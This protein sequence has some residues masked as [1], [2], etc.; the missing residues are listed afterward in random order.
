MTR[1]AEFE[2]DGVDSRSAPEQIAAQLHQALVSGS[3]QPGDRLPPEPELADGFG[4]SRSTVRE[5]LKLLRGQ[6]LLETQRGSK[7]GHFVATPHA[8]G[9]AAELGR[10]FGIW[11]DI[12]EISVAEVDEARHVVER[13]CVQLAAKRATREDLDEMGRILDAQADPSISLQEFLNLDVAFHQAISTAA[14]NYLLS[15]PMSAIHMVRPRTNTL[16]QRHDRTRV[17]TQHRAL[18]EAIS[19]GDAA[20]AEAAIL[21][22]MSFLEA[23]RDA[24]L[25]SSVADLPSIDESGAATPSA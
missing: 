7:G 3:L 4:V 21:N 16:I 12:G 13:A 2:P 24:D 11:F 6:G 25:G 5:A 17:I 19:S 15:L 10:T 22:H 1:H 20:A 23:Q 14:R 9:V 8:E 18:L